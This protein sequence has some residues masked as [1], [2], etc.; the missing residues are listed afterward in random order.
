VRP[1]DTFLA[2]TAKPHL[3]IV[4]SDCQHDKVLFVR[5][6]TDEAGKDSTCRLAVGDHPWITHPSVVHYGGAMCVERAVLDAQI[7]VNLDASSPVAAAILTKVIKGF[8]LSVY[9]KPVDQDFAS[10][11]CHCEQ[12][13]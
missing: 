5:L 3:A 9:A 10:G 12:P 11:T 6:T 8:A 7:G 1:G 2:R 4:V 13:T